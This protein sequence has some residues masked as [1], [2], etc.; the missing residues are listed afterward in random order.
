MAWSSER[1]S[2]GD[3][4]DVE[5]ELRQHREH[6]EL[7]LGALP[8]VIYRAIGDP[9]FKTTWVSDNVGELT[10]YTAAEYCTE[11]LWFSRLHPDDMSML[12]DNLKGMRPG[13]VY[14]SE[15]RWRH[16]DGHYLWIAD[17]GRLVR[18]GD[19]APLE[20]FGVALETTE[21]RREEAQRRQ[22]LDELITAQELERK[23][24]SR[25]LHDALGQ[26]LSSLS[27][28]IAAVDDLAQRG[29]SV[30]QPL[31][32]VRRVADMAVREL[33]QLAHSLRPPAIDELGFVSALH[34][35]IRELGRAH[36]ITVDVHIRG[37]D[38]AGR[39]P[40]AVEASLY[41]MVQ[42]ALHNVI[43]HARAERAS[44]LIDYT[45]KRIT[46]IV[47]D[48]GV[49]FVASSAD[50][51]QGG[52]GLASIQERAA[53]LGGKAAVESRPGGGTTVRVTVPLR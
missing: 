43:K 7:I 41:R 20:L 37:L 38:P 24:I 21:R 52:L 23:R 49:G 3:E 53:I 27:I 6:M 39:L 32:D 5:R 51:G 50:G 46:L 19:G 26:T 45:V 11:G 12:V 28:H 48:D 40:S 31:A 1:A 42:E 30:L 9:S 8:V 13:T 22:L 47:E 36:G 35:L 16:K 15:Y 18:G 10:G 25:E 17:R 2:G 33:S 4:V 34:G 44:V 29:E 14:E